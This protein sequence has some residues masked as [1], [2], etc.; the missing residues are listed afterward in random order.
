MRQRHPIRAVNLKSTLKN[1]SGLYAVYG[2][3]VVIPL[4]IT[5]Y[6][7][8]ILGP[9][10]WGKVAAAQ[11]FALLVSLV[12]DFGLGL[13]GV[14]AVS[15][16]RSKPLELRKYMRNALGARVLLIGALAM[17]GF[18]AAVSA[19]IDRSLLAGAILLGLAQGLNVTWYFQGHERMLQAVWIELAGRLAGGAL[20]MWFVREP[21]DAW[22]ML[23]ALAGGHGIS[24]LWGNIIAHSETRTCTP[25]IAG[26]LSLL[27]T[28]KS[29]FAFKGG[30]AIYTSCNTLLL[31]LI[32][33]ADQVAY[34]AAADRLIRAAIGA[35]GPMGQA[36]FVRIAAGIHESPDSASREAR[37][38]TAFITACGLAGGIAIWT[39]GDRA[40]HALFGPEYGQ[41]VPVLMLLTIL[42]PL[43]A[44]SS[45]LAATWILPAGHES[46]LARIIL[47]AGVLN[48]CLAAL[49]ARPLGAAGM[50]AAVVATELFVLAA[51][52]ALV[53]RAR[54]E[55]PVAAAAL[56]A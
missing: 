50:A 56:G 55:H 44:A 47:V 30:V 34:F 27:K 48:V 16:L 17:L 5:P 46:S 8:R 22:L 41:A 11:G 31:S 35:L 21:Q 51:C 54:P 32:S 4:V 3:N 1:A 23:I 37:S 33:T 39:F 49:I 28:A 26:G 9:D 15:Q 19:P 24:A 10:T 14:R 45:S 2:C 6:A 36:M 43:V 7:A 38:S 53:R 29:M 18:L 25:S 13:T 20:V 40:I 12:M 52:L 42:V